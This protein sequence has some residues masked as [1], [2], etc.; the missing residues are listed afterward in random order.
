MQIKK[1]FIIIAVTILANWIYLP[2]N[3]NTVYL[4]ETKFNDKVDRVHA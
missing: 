2:V 1:L 3:A 4:H